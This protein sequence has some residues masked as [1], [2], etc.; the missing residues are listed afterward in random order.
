MNNWNLID[1]DNPDATFNL[2]VEGLSEEEFT[3]EDGKDFIY[4]EPEELNDNEL[5]E[6]ANENEL[7]EVGSEYL[8]EDGSIDLDSLRELNKDDQLIR[9]REYPDTFS[10][11]SGR[12]FIFFEDLGFDFPDDI[13]ISVI[14]G[15][16]PSNDWQG[17][18]VNGISSVVKLQLFLL[19][20]SIKVNFKFDV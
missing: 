3:L 4:A 11:P 12:A 13:D 2:T 8:L 18:V 7:L 16:S 9:L 6:W 20:N 15:Y 10:S 19:E 1:F 17:V 14:D 5:I